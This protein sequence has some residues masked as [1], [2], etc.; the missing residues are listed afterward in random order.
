MHVLYYF[1]YCLDA[2]WKTPLHAKCILPINFDIGNPNRR[3]DSFPWKLNYFSNSSLAV[4]L[5]YKKQFFRQ[6]SVIFFHVL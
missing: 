6:T 2:Q 4:K 3:F 5:H 1:K